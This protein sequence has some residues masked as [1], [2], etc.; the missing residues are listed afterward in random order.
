MDLRD[1]L[2][3]KGKKRN[4]TSKNVTYCVIGNRDSES[5][6]R[7]ISIACFSFFC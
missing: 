2:E 5:N 6:N 4:A 7:M 1:S 3:K